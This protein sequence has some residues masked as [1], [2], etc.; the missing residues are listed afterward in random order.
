[1]FFDVEFFSTF[2]SDLSQVEAA[3][4]DENERSARTELA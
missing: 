2:C 1:M 4:D 3:V